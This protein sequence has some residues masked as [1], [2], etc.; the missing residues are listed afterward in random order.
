MDLFTQTGNGRMPVVVVVGDIEGIRMQ[1]NPVPIWIICVF[2]PG[3]QHTAEGYHIPGK[4][5]DVPHR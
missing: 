4:I 1:W 5:P 2:Q 3:H